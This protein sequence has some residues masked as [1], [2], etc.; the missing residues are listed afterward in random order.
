MTTKQKPPSPLAEA[1]S[2]PKKGRPSLLTPEAHANILESIRAGNYIETACLAAGVG[3]SNYYNW[4]K[5]GKEGRE[6][7]HSF[8]EDCARARA[9][10]EQSLVAIAQAGDERGI[11][12][13]PSK[14]AGWMLE[15]TRA[16]KFAA[17]LKL[18]LERELDKILG[19]AERV[20]EPDQYTRLIEA[21]GAAASCS[22]AAS[23]DSGE[24]E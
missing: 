6:P 14:A 9:E 17:S 5:W 19:I 8:F 16:Q 4:M 13:G 20:L 7:Y 18:N 3:Y 22:E 21:I 12:Y 23:P 10:N 2:E 11:S 24:E 15:R 1:E